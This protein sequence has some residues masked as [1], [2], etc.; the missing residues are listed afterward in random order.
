MKHTALFIAALTS[1]VHSDF[2]EVVL[3]LG[4]GAQAELSEG[5]LQ[6]IV[7]RRIT[8]YRNAFVALRTPEKVKTSHLKKGNLIQQK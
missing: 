5:I 2:D 6:H 1:I 4:R 8:R 7:H 3:G